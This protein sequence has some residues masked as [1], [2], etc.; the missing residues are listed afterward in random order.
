MEIFS[1][2]RGPDTAGNEKNTGE[3][4]IPL[5]VKICDILCLAT[6]LWADYPTR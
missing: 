6:R 3:W 4:M 1:K 5:L 2:K